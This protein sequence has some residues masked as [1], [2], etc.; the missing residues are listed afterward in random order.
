[1]PAVLGASGI[2]PHVG[3]GK[4]EFYWKQ[5]SQDVRDFVI[6]YPVCQMETSSHQKPTGTLMPLEL[7]ERKWDHVAIDFVIGLPK[8][9]GMN[10]ICT[11][12]DKATKIV[13][14]SPVP[15]K[16]KQRR[17]ANYIGNMSVGFMAFLA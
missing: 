3:P 7:P 9:D 12:V 13:I 15:T 17:L 2:C 14:S 10:T 11:V 6:Y 16:L 5:M 1:M 8:E 4:A